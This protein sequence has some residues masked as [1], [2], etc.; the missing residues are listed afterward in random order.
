MDNVELRIDPFP[1]EDELA[2]LRASAW[3]R[4]AGDAPYGGVLKRS[5][6]H[7]GA[8]SGTQLVGFVNVAWDGGVH[9]FLLDT[10][11]HPDFRRL[12]IAVRLVAE[13]RETARA[14]GTGWLHVD[15]EP[16][17]QSL[18]YDAC[19]FR[20]TLAGLIQLRPRGTGT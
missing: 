2:V 20:P 10:C 13:A 15:F 17:L 1:S 6:C 5:L 11:V 3:G 8:Y 4:E 7:V 16:H 9:A 14:R 19:G 18:Y 12:G